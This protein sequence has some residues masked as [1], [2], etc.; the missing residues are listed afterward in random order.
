M[1]PHCD[2]ALP[3]T[4]LLMQKPSQASGFGGWITLLF[5]LVAVVMLADITDLL[6]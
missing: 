6:N 2:I 5:T 4:T 1:C 3:D